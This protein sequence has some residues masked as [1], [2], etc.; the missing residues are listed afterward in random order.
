MAIRKSEL[1]LSIL[2]RA[3]KKYTAQELSILAQRTNNNW[4]PEQ[5]K[6]YET[7]GGAP[8]LDMNYTVF[9]KW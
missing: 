6:T 1:R 7:E 4:T 8:F 3:R 5:L 9:E 2:Y